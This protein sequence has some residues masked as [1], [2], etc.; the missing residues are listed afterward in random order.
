MRPYDVRTQLTS[1]ADYFEG[2]YDKETDPERKK[3]WSDLYVETT[4]V[5][6]GFSML[7]WGEPCF[8]STE[9]DVK[10]E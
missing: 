8:Y 4:R 7:A 3:M 1:L 6:T 10:K 9:E 5:N 2:R